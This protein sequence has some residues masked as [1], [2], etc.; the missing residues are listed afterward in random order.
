MAVKEK[1][2]FNPRIKELLNTFTITEPTVYRPIFPGRANCSLGEE[3]K[4]LV[5]DY[6][7]VNFGSPPPRVIHD[8]EELLEIVK[9]DLLRLISK[10]FPELE[11]IEIKITCPAEGCGWSE[12]KARA[13]LKSEEPG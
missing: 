2:L 11:D 10:A 3:M 5:D 9:G 13:Y 4:A 6:V 12:I 7:E 1:L 8:N